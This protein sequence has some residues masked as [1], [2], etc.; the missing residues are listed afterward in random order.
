VW[1]HR[2]SVNFHGPD[3]Y[4]RDRARDHEL[5]KWGFRVLH[6]LADDGVRQVEQVRD[7]I[8]EALIRSPE[9]RP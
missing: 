8:L 5:E 9:D 2:Q 6:F 7:R 3:D 4:G 1:R